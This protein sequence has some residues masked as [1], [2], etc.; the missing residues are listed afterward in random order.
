MQRAGI[1]MNC[2]VEEVRNTANYTDVPA[3]RLDAVLQHHIHHRN[4]FFFIL[5]FMSVHAYSPSAYVLAQALLSFEQFVLKKKNTPV[6]L[7]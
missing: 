6:A 5:F 2:W 7:D 4:S 1:H 3:T